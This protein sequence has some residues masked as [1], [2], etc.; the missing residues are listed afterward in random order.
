M[1][2]KR[3][4]ALTRALIG[5][6]IVAQTLAIPAPAS[7]AVGDGHVCWFFSPSNAPD[8]LNE[9]RVMFSQG[10]ICNGL[11]AHIDITVELLFHGFGGAGTTI[12]GRTGIEYNVTSTMLGTFTPGAYCDS[13]IYSGRTTATVRYKSG[14]P[15]YI[16]RQVTSPQ[17]T[18]TCNPRPIPTD[19]MPTTVT[20]K[21]P[22]PVPTVG[23]AAALST[24]NMFV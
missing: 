18:R 8:N 22:T 5:A 3:W 15:E 17:V 7:A 10:V 23:T 13:G 2:S 16:T 20:V 11:V 9:N 14:Y 4:S 6:V 21:A 12:N 19:S 24:T 1:I